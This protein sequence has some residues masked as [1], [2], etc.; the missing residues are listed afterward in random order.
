M[1]NPC[2][3][4]QKSI[5]TIH[6]SSPTPSGLLVVA[7]QLPATEGV[8]N[9]VV[10][11]MEPQ[12]ILQKHNPSKRRRRVT[13]R[14]E[15]VLKDV[16]ALEA[17]PYTDIF[18]L[19]AV[20][21]NTFSGLSGSGEILLSRFQGLEPLIIPFSKKVAVKEGCEEYYCTTSSSTCAAKV[22][23]IKWRRNSIIIIVPNP[24]YVSSRF[25]SFLCVHPQ[26]H[27]PQYSTTLH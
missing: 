15:R 11:W 14:R 12:S 3:K 21:R 4:P 25:V 19:C 22:K 8:L 13:R 24:V 27:H 20:V 1:L 6:T 2:P 9:Y 7:T 17:Y 10:L 23:G 16:K 5:P 18:N 26:L